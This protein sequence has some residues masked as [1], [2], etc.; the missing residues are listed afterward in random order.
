MHFA[1]NV[2][3]ILLIFVVGG[4]VQGITP[5]HALTAYTAHVKWVGYD[6]TDDSDC[7]DGYMNTCEN[8]MKVKRTIWASCVS[9][10][11][12]E[13]VQKNNYPGGKYTFGYYEI[14]WTSYNAA[15]CLTFDFQMIENSAGGST[16]I[17]T[18]AILSSGTHVTAYPNLIL[19]TADGE[20]R[21][22]YWLT[23]SGI[24]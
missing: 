24:F 8:K 10:T 2:K 13:G 11:W 18:F 14:T 1:K 4:L 5:S 17:H 16:S 15:P 22:E 9:K 20:F 6:F 19:G 12:T 21:I 23:S 7:G 3:I